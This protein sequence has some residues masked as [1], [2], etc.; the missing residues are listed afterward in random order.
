M[1]RSVRAIVVLLLSVLTAGARAGEA[2]A[3]APEGGADLAASQ[4]IA[5]SDVV[6]FN[7]GVQGGLQDAGMTN[8]V[9]AGLFYPFAANTNSAWFADFRVDLN[10][11]DYNYPGQDY[12]SSSINDVQVSGVTL[13]TSTRLGYRWLGSKASRA[14]GV[15]FGFDSRSLK[16][17]EILDDQL[18]ALR[19]FSQEVFFS[20]VAASVATV[21]RRSDASVYALVPIG[22]YGVGS[23]RVA[24][25]NDVFAASPL[26]TIG[27]DL[28]YRFLPSVRLGGGIY[29]QANQ[30]EEPRYPYAVNGFGGR[31]SLS[32]FTQG[33]SEL[34]VAT[35]VDGNFQLR[36]SAGFV[37][38]LGAPSLDEK[39][40]QGLKA[41]LS[42]LSSSPANRY[43]RVN[44]SEPGGTGEVEQCGD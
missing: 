17:G 12:L 37:L 44:C 39:R 1:A 28:G 4:K 21:G 18:N 35:S 40:Y 11:G 13:S 38:R 23:H 9:G 5:V 32:Y 8:R 2:G 10:L 31:A 6:K 42:W 43:V 20:Q 29:H 25:I 33:P 7:W 19:G 34:Y 24:R 14:Y 41:P 22:Y 27:V 15:D 26:R 30:Y 16:P 36:Y 3:G